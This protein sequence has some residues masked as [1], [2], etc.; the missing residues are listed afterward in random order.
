MSSLWNTAFAVVYLCT[1]AVLGAQQFDVASIKPHGVPLHV[2]AGRTISGRSLK[3]EGYNLRLLLLEAFDL[4]PYQLEMSAKDEIFYDISAVTDG[5]ELNRKLA[6]AM[7]RNLLADRFG[8]KSH[9]Y[10]KQIEAFALV[11]VK[12]GAKLKPAAADKPCS[13]PTK[14]ALPNY[15]T[16]FRSCGIDMLAE[17]VMNF[18]RAPLEDET[19]LSGTYDF[20]LVYSPHGDGTNPDEITLQTALRD[21][22]LK[23]EKRTI[24]VETVVIDQISPPSPN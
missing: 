23:L 20:D 1:T 22:G 18:N 11:Q 21:L 19:G 14:V 15:L 24:T 13:A 9:R 4:K 16:E 8:L 17:I 2:I 5:T 3:L 6:R 10:S 12:T 7:L